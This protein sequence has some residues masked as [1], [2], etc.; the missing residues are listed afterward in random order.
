M[1]GESESNVFIGLVVLEEP[2]H[3]D[4]RGS[5]ERFECTKRAIFGLGVRWSRACLGLRCG[6]SRALGTGIQR[7]A[8]L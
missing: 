2:S 3:V 8:Y 7:Q 5:Q 6:V 1:E 4:Q